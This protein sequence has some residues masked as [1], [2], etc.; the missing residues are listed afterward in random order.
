MLC[1]GGMNYRYHVENEQTKFNIQYGEYDYVVL[2]NVA[3]PMEDYSEMEKYG[4]IL[5]DWCE[6]YG[7]QP[8]LYSTWTA[9]K[10]G[11]ALQPTM[12]KTYEDLA[13][14]TSAIIAPVGATWWQ[15]HEAF[16]YSE[17]YLFDGEH[18]S[19]VG[20]TLAAL[21]IASTIT[22]QKLTSSDPM[23]LRILSVLQK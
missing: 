5:I 7:A 23:R 4:K 15:F 22:K 3:H 11:E 16:P 6:Q 21:T 8:V 17:L 20:S 18:A 13:C 2:Q 12:A 14:N 9:K 1:R 19:Y 10:D